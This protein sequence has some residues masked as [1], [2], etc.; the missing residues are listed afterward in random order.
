MSIRTRLPLLALLAALALDTPVLHAQN[1]PVVLRGGQLF[2][3]LSD[4]LEPNRGIVLMQ[5]KILVLDEADTPLE[6]SNARI[7]T[8]AA[9]EVILAGIVDAHA[10][11]N[12]NLM[13]RPRTEELHVLPVLFL[14]NGVTTTFPNGEYNPWGMRDLRLRIEAGVQVGP[15]LINSGPYFGSAR[16]GWSNDISAD[17]IR[18]EV[19]FWVAQG[20]GGFKAKGPQPEHLRPLIERA[21][22]HGLTVTGHLDSGFR[23]SV[24]PRDA[25]LWGIDRVEHFLGGD[26]FPDT[27]S[28][29]ASFPEQDVNSPEFQAIV[30]LFVTHGATYDATLTA[31]GYFSDLSDD[32]FELWTDESRFFTEDVRASF[33]EFPPHQF[34]AQFQAIWETKCAEVEAFHA[35]GGTISLGTDHVTTGRYLAPFGVHREMHALNKC[36]IPNA[37]V[38]RIATINAARALGVGDRVGTVEAGKLADLVIIRGNPLEEIRSTRNVR[39]V[40]RNGEIYDPESLFRSVEGRLAPMERDARLPVPGR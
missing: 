32:V 3:G 37:D 29:Y 34:M 8:L 27:R 15:R 2:T 21:H 40:I 16:P 18:Q 26:H 20:V 25:V 10:H 11:Y 17:S 13:G 14:A 35:R 28:A 23:N 6:L 39:L 7:V 19:D 24:N 12:V 38:L 30:D 33:E 5:G 36:G 31:Y 9:D 4:T 22:L 1:P